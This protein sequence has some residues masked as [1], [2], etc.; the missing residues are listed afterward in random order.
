MEGIVFDIVEMTVNDGPGV[1][2]TVFLK[3][4]PLRCQWCHNP[5]GLSFQPQR[6]VS[7]AGCI[8]CG[9]CRSV[10]P[11]PDACIACG[12]CVKVCPVRLR[13]IVGTVYQPEE[14]A[15]LLRK[16]QDFLARM[17]GG[18]TFSGGEPTAQPEF[19]ISVLKLLKGMHRAIETCGFCDTKIFQQILEHVDYVIM[20]IKLVDS[21]KHRQFTGVDNKKI[22]ANLAYLKQSGLPF[23]IRVPLIPGVNDHHENL[24]QTAILL[25]GCSTLEGVEL[26]PYHQTAGAKY[27]MVGIPY[28]PVFDVTKETHRDTQ[29]FE[30]RG[31]PCRCL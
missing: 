11:S 18:V 21:Q 29:V 14:L 26:L 13:R 31:I 7:S 25:E 30:R 15:V 5:E 1:R 23:L 12:E 2:T 22:L 9:A 28:A 27:P 16:H 17:E 20:D 24:E 6:M 19:L 8:N 4:C 10:C 3:G